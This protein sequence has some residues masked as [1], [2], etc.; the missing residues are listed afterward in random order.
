LGLCPE[1][2]EELW[3]RSVA[4]SVSCAQIE[5]SS[6]RIRGQPTAT[7]VHLQTKPRSKTN[8]RNQDRLEVRRT[9]HQCSSGTISPGRYNRSQSVRL[10]RT[11]GHRDCRSFRN[12]IEGTRVSQFKRI[13]KPK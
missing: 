13:D 3:R 5:A 8:V 10:A 9:K 2:L 11:V 4:H 12:M 6:A 7:L 1:P